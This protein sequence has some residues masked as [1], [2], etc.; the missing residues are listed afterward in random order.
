VA[1]LAE[2][3]LDTTALL[4]FLPVVALGAGASAVA[5]VARVVLD[6]AIGVSWT[7]FPPLARLGLAPR[8]DLLLEV[9]E[10]G[11]FS[12]TKLAPVR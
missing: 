7:F 2:E 8:L 1:E 9:L 4:L 3:L 12:T 5:L 6:L 11:V 10:M